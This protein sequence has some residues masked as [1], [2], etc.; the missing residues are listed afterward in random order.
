[1]AF[2]QMWR[3][4]LR[5]GWGQAQRLHYTDGELR[6]REGLAS[7]RG[8]VPARGRTESMSGA[9]FCKT[10]FSVIRPSLVCLWALLLVWR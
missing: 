10:E 3:Q 8:S 9:L 1:M 6:L 4:G 5:E 2:V 7:C